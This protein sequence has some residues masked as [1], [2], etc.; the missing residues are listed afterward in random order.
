MAD[1]ND[2]KYANGVRCFNPHP[3]APDFVKG[4]V[5]IS[6]NALIAWAKANPDCLSEYE[7]DGVK[8][9]Q[10]KLQIKEGDNGIYTQLD[11]YGTDAYVDPKTA[12]AQDQGSSGKEEETEDLPF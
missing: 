3:N 4:T 11:L 9:K 8:D 1:V 10:I 12:K 7:K 6:L 2:K 5:I